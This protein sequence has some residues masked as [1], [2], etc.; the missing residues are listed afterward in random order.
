[1]TEEIFTA[2]K[3][4]GAFLNGRQLAMRDNP[5][6]GPMVVGTGLPTPNLTN[7]EGAYAW[8][9][10]I[11]APIGAVRVLG[12]TASCCAYVACGRFTGYFEQ[13]GL[14]DRAAGVLL[15][16]EA[17]GIVT[18]WWDVGQPISKSPAC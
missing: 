16:E 1:M 12:S 15:V 5:D 17:G 8:L 13:T 7:Y 10:Q 14:V 6:I 4:R 3:G 9:D 18:D 11:R 2:E